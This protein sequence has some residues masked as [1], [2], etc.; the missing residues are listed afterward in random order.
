MLVAVQ[1]VDKA[2]SF[3]RE[4]RSLI[5][6]VRIVGFG[7][8]DYDI[9]LLFAGDSVESVLFVGGVGGDVTDA[10]SSNPRVLALD[11]SVGALDFLTVGVDG[12]V[13][14]RNNESKVVRFY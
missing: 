8:F 6:F 9:G 4:K 5:S 2:T 13:V 3:I 14:V 1:A 11:D 7:K 10:V 12:V